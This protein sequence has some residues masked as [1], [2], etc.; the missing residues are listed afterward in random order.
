MKP[1]F[2][3]SIRVAGAAITGCALGASLSLSR[4]TPGILPHATAAENAPQE[5][6]DGLLKARYDTAKALLDMEERR[7]RDGVTTLGHVCETARW[8]R[9]SAVELPIS[10]QERFGALTNYVNLTRRLEA[11]VERAAAQ[12]AAPPS[13]RESARYL[14]LDAEITLLRSE[15][16]KRLN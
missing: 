6:L 15:L 7:L 9:D 1:R 8:V 3:N 5:E 10:T 16:R 4:P 13:D 14:R 11:S 12:G 2:L